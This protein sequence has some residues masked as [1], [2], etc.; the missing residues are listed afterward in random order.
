ML[1]RRQVFSVYRQLLRTVDKVFGEDILVKSK[2]KEE[3]KSEIRKNRSETDHNK[4]LELIK[5]GIQTDRVLRYGVLQG[6]LNNSGNYQVSLPEGFSDLEGTSGKP[7]YPLRAVNAATGEF[8]NECGRR[9]RA[10][11]DIPV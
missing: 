6:R 1:L 8:Q 3:I 5:V 2:A 4:I 7:N 10:D 9:G 11:R